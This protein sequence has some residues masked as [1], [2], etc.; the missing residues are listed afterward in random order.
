L[1]GSQPALNNSSMCMCGFAGVIT[2][3]FPGQ[4]PIMVP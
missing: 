2:M 1:M 4:V 3:T